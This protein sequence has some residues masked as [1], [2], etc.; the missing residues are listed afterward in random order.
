MPEC[1]E[2]GKEFDSESALNGHQVA[3]SEK[4]KQGIEERDLSGENNP[5]YSGGKVTISCEECNKEFKVKPARKDSARF[6]SYEC[7]NQARSRNYKKNGMGE[8]LPILEG[9]DNPNYGKDFSGKKSPKWKEFPEKHCLNCGKVFKVKPSRQNIAK[10]CSKDCQDKWMSE[11]WKK[12]GMGKRLPNMY[13]EEN[14]NWKGGY[15]PYYGPNWTDQRQKALDRDNYTC[16]KCGKSDEELGQEPDVHHKKPLRTF[17][18]ENEIDYQK[19]NRIENLVTLC[20]KCHLNI[21]NMNVIP[22]FH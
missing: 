22:Q 14:P 6:C 9:K 17:K 16:Q 21:E 15:E 2:C 13:G 11:E 1:S 19:A 5:A 4:Y 3:H 10:L 8:R 18:Q 12:R 20:R 7:T